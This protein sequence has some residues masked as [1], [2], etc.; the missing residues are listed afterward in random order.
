MVVVGRM[1]VW[2]SQPTQQR[3]EGYERLILPD[4]ASHSQVKTNVTTMVVEGVMLNANCGVLVHV[5]LS[6]LLSV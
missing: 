5:I 6:K 3:S 4:C 2:S 1:E